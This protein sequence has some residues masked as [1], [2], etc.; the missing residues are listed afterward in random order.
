[1]STMLRRASRRNGPLAGAVIAVCIVAIAGFGGLATA[2][3]SDWYRGLDRPDWQPPGWVFGPVWTTL[4]VMLGVSAWLA[5]RDVEGPDRPRILGLYAANGALNLGWT[6]IFFRA[7]EPTAAG[8][9]IVALLATIVLL[10][11][12][13]WPHNRTAALLLVPYALWVAFATAL[14]WRIA[15]AN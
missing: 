8:I 9:E 12:G 15:V 10:I 1:M 5:W 11:R 13:T 3:E 2:P 14:T 4:Y 6:L 7:Q